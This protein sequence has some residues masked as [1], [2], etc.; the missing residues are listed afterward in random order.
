MTVVTIEDTISYGGQAFAGRPVEACIENSLPS[1]D[2]ILSLLRKKRVSGNSRVL[3]AMSVDAQ[4][5]S[6]V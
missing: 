6:L 5:Y 1:G 4:V 2:P 3:Q